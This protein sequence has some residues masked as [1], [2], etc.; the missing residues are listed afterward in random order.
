MQMLT[1][2]EPAITFYS[3]IWSVIQPCTSTIAA[4]LPT[5]GPAFRDG[6]SLKSLLASVRSMLSLSSRSRDSDPSTTEVKDS[7]PSNAGWNELYTASSEGVAQPTGRERIE[8][9]SK[10]LDG[11]DL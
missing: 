9:T 5:Y 1:L 6:R 8:L 2:F 11:E 4:C 3:F 7:T 10:K